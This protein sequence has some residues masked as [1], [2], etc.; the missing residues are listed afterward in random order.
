MNPR[1][2]C[3]RVGQYVFFSLA[4]LVV[5]GA[6]G[7]WYQGELTVPEGWAGRRIALVAEYVNSFAVVYLDGKKV[8]EARFPA[9]EVDLPTA[10]R[11][12][13]KQVLS[14]LVVALPLKGVLLS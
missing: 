8:G 5:G 6:A 1:W 14:L 9:G 11:P 7:A 4:G 13:R 3:R 10:C 12:G 2:W